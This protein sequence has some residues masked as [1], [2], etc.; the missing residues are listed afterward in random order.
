MVGRMNAEPILAAA[1]AGIF[2]FAGIV[3]QSRKTRRI[4]TDEH[5]ENSRKLDRIEQKVDQTAIRVEN[6]SDRLDDHIV[7]HNM[8][9]RKPWW[10][11]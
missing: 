3:W 10:R 11:K 1:V 6:V 5:S 7:I 4:N 9:S 8:T 2:A